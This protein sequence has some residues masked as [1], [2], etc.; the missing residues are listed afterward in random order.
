MVKPSCKAILGLRREET[1][2]RIS[3]SYEFRSTGDGRLERVKGAA[4]YI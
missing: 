2:T 3:R 1:G 4:E